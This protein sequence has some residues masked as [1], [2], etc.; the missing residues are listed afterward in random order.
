MSIRSPTSC[1]DDHLSHLIRRQ[2]PH[3][4]LH[5]LIRIDPEPL[6]LG[7][8]RKLHILAIQLLLHDLLQRLEHQ[9]LSLG[10]CQTLMEFVLEFGLSAL[11]AGTDGFGVVAVECAGWFG[12]V[13]I[14]IIKKIKS[15]KHI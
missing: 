13:S 2:P 6:L 8:T 1:Q 9:H 3:N 4:L 10:Q 14:I 7:H 12:V 11:G 5:L 15:M